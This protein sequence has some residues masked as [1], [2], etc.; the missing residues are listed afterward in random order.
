MT[1]GQ[2]NFWP[3]PYGEITL[4]I[5]FE[6]KVIDEWNGYQNVC[7]EAPNRMIPNMTNFDLI[8]PVTPNGR[9][10]KFWNG[11]FWAKVSITRFFPTR[12]ARWCQIRW[13]RANSLE[14][15]IEKR[16]IWKIVLDPNTFLPLAPKRL[17]WGQIWELTADSP[18]H[19]ASAV[20]FSDWSYLS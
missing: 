20:F 15:I 9:E 13:C 3:G 5:T 16:K 17:A 18:V 6:P 12:E 4:P 19:C 14:V 2:A 11:L 10:V 7:L 1:S 8:W